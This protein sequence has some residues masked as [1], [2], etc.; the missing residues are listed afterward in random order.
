MNKPIAALMVI[1]LLVMLAL[2][3]CSPS[4]NPSG[5]LNQATISAL[6]GATLSVIQTEQARNATA[7]PTQQ[8]PTTTLYPTRTLAPSSTPIP[9]ST[10]FPTFTPVTATATPTLTPTPLTTYTGGVGTGGSSGGVTGGGG[11]NATE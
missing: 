5:P 11:G 4:I 7:T 8:P 10:P 9:T 2:A 3:G 1:G 6:A